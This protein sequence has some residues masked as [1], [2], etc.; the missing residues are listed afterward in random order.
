MSDT[1]QISGV[2]V[3]FSFGCMSGS[4]KDA[5]ITKEV[6]DDKGAGTDAGS[7][8]N[9]LFPAKTCGKKNTFTALRTHLGAMRSWHYNNSFI[10]EDSVWRIL[11]EKRIEAYKQV[12]EIDGKARAK[13]LLTAFEDDL[14]NLIDLARLGR[15]E[16]FKESDYPTI[17]TVRS[18]FKYSVDYR[19]IPSSAGLN[20]ALMA[21]AI[22]KL[23]ELHARRLQEANETLVARFL[24]PFKILSEQ[25]QDTKKRKI[26]PVLDSIRE[27]TQ[28]V[29]SLDLSGNQE[30]VN[31]AAS[32]SGVF[33]GMTP[34]LLR[35]DEQMQKLVGETCN[36]VVTALD[37]FGK[38]GA[39]S[40]A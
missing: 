16:A 21:E 29:P 8:S 7:W 26:G 32:I 38:A 14:P 10:F 9:K 1:K 30:L 28:I 36:Q 3:A 27:F 12:V 17:E 40:F 22:E 13:E 15:G 37:R 4:K 5:E 39:R 31:L 6:C 33:E 19:P 23:N 25:L 35:R 18:M 11:P 34:E 20:P 2:L 24:E